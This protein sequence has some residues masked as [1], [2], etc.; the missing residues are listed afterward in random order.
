MAPVTSGSTGR[1]LPV[2]NDN[3]ALR[4][5]VAVQPYGRCSVCSLKLNQCHAWQSSAMSFAL[6]IL[7]LV[8][9]FAHEPWMVRLSV[10]ACLLLLVIQ[11]MTSHKRTDE[12]IFGQHEL[13]RT[14]EK[15]RAT[16]ADLE[17]ARQGLE[18][19]VTART[20]KLRQTNVALASA[21]LE[22]AE[23]AR[24]REEMVLEVSHDLRTPL[25]SVKGAAD[26]LLD[27]IVG[28]LGD[29]QRE[30]VEIVRDH[31][32]RLIEAVSR[33][34]QGARDQSVRVVLQPASVEVGA[35][36]R[37]VVRS[38]QPIAEERGVAVEVSGASVETI[39]DVDKLRKVIENLVGNAL[40]FT[41]R[42]GSVRVAVEHD[43]ADVRITVH[44]TG[45][46]MAEGDVDRVFDRF[47]RGRED[48]PGS[49]LGLAIT[50]DLVR[51]HGGDVLARS[52]LGKGS[53]FS[54][55]LPRSAT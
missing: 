46:G 13:S 41:D 21:N 55:V 43:A 33:L 22:L 50:R 42:G 20:E 47:Y 5:N 6:V 26:N 3:C 15:L 39:A 29:S 31:A 30:Y 12:L 35:L 8:P 16:N 53:T 52:A 19:D 45:V 37:D 17:D 11:G 38:L 1:K 32:A 2:I 23:L 25:T 7:L 34:L 27:G 51:L 54:A 49:G 4:R 28:P 24:R 10:A 40:K 14:S 44:D 36:A 18:R 48:R 9:L